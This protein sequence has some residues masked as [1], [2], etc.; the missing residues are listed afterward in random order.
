[1]T[2]SSTE[3][4]VVGGHDVSPQILGTSNFPSEQGFK[5]TDTVLCQ[6]TSAQYYWIKM[7]EPPVQRG[8]STMNIRYF[9][10]KDC[11]K[12]GDLRI[13]YCPTEEMVADFFTKPLQSSLFRQ[14][15]AR[16]MNYESSCSKKQQ[17]TEGVCWE[18]VISMGPRSTMRM[19]TSSGMSQPRRRSSASR[20]HR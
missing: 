10:I 6:D 11:V 5:V 3:S 17:Q 7:E 1:M 20:M 12:A 14:L 18:P 4:E 9:F 2:Q 19:M 13:E 16:I 8:P 15:T